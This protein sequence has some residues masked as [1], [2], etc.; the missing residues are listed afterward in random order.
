MTSYRLELGDTMDDIKPVI[1]NLAGKE[2]LKP[3]HLKYLAE[4]K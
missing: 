4:I 3:L 1:V 2:L